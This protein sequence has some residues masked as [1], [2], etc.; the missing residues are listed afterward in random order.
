[1]SMGFLLPTP[2]EA[3]IWRG[4]M[5]ISI[6]KQFQRMWSGESWTI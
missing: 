6:I 4:P 3:V 1:M 2:D 5:K